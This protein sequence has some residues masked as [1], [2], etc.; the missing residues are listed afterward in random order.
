MRGAARPERL[1][2][3]SAALEKTP[4]KPPTSGRAKA[5][6]A[7]RER[8]MARRDEELERRWSKGCVYL[9]CPEDPLATAVL[10]LIDI[11]FVVPGV[12]V[13]MIARVARLPSVVV[14]AAV[15]VTWACLFLIAAA[16]ALCVWRERR[17][18]K[19]LEGCD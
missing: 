7:G 6:T 8:R 15:W 13:P 2:L 5:L 10:V 18:L 9:G 1:R 16:V 11:F 4:Y 14:Q 19:G 3:S 12:I 17:R